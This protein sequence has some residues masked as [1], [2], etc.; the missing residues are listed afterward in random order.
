MQR[1][2]TIKDGVIINAQNLGISNFEIVKTLKKQFEFINIIL[3]ND[4]KC[5]A[6]CEKTYG[7]LKKY[8]DSIF[9][10]LGTG[11][12]GAVF[13]NGKM[14]SSKNAPGFE[15]G[16]MIIQKDGVKC[17]C[18]NKGCF[19]AY[20]SM[21]V[22]KEKIASRKKKKEITGNECYEVIKND[23]EGKYKDIVEDFIKSLN[24]GISNCI[25]IFEPEAICL[26]GGFVHFEDLLMEKLKL[27][28]NN[29]NLTFNKRL[30]EIF[31]A[32]MGNDAGIIGS[33]ILQK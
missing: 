2:G 30:P 29:N 19:E 26:G 1:L 31:I 3:R 16:H 20:A 25:N 14:L 10:C 15:I 21:R 13:F 12:G 7:S 18:G 24:V 5:A 11:I 22:L 6:L 8:D 33:T 28:M 4:A 27:E 23:V 17:S 9:I 32:K